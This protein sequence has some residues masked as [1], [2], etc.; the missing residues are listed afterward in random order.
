VDRV[1]SDEVWLE[2]GGSNKSRSDEKGSNGVKS[3]GIGSEG[4]GWSHVKWGQIVDIS[5]LT[6]KLSKKNGEI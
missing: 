3:V 2:E 5:N 4:V 6:S 1:I